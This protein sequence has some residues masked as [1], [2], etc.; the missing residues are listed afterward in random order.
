MAGEVERQ[1]SAL[2]GAYRLR[3]FEDI[4]D[5]GEVRQ[6]L[7][8]E[9]NGLIIYDR[10]GWMSAVLS[11]SDRPA[12]AEDD[13]L[14]GSDDERVRAFST[15]SGFAGRWS[16]E[17][18][19]VIHQLTVATFPNWVGTTQRRRYD[20]VDGELWLHPPRLLMNGKMRRSELRWERLG[21][22]RR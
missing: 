12:F 6:P 14:E 5:D 18:G 10:S 11:T 22:S 15:S 9:P 4:A 13:I 21:R 19:E 16:I 20:L 7:G 1:S 2:A 8:S 17:D 3:S